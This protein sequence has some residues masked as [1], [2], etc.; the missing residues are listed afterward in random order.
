MCSNTAQ[1]RSRNDNPYVLSYITMSPTN[2]LS[3]SSMSVFFVHWALINIF[4]SLSVAQPSNLE[5]PR[6]QANR[7]KTR[8]TCYAV[9]LL[10]LGKQCGIFLELLLTLGTLFATKTLFLCGLPL[11]VVTA[12]PKTEKKQK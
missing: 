9:K 6:V 2:K 8:M 5:Y 10:I 12:A 11:A 4:V 7:F 3:I 1:D